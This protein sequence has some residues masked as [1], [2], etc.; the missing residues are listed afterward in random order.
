MIKSRR[1]RPG[2]A[3]VQPSKQ[4]QELFFSKLKDV[5]IGA[6]VEGKSGFINL[7]KIKSDYFDFVFGGLKEEV[8]RRT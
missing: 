5:F 2:S 7:M 6:E 1:S 4:N 8:Q 3:L